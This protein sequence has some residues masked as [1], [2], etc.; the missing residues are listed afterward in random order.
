MKQAVVLI[1]GIGEQK[2]METLRR[3]VAAIL[4]PAAEGQEQYWSKPDR[5]SELFELRRLKTPGRTKTDFYEYYWAYQVEGTKLWHL[6]QWF[7]GLLFRRWR[8]I[9]PGL[10]GIWL[11]SWILLGTFSILAALGMGAYAKAWYAVQP[12]GSIWVV[13]ML[14]ITAMEGFLIYYVGD[15]ARY[16]SPS[17]GNIALRQKIRAEG[18]RLLRQLHDSHEYERII[19]VGHSL[20]SVIGYDIIAR[21]WLDYNSVYDF[22]TN[23]PIIAQLLVDRKQPQ[24]VISD[25]LYKTGAALSSDANSDALQQFREAQLDAWKEQRR[26]GNPWRVSDFVTMGSPLAH[27]ML[28]LASDCKDFEARKRQRELPSCP[29]VT[30]KKG[31][32]YND[33]TKHP[34]GKGMLFSPHILHH[35]AAFAVT[36]WTNLYFPAFFG[37]FGD[38][39]GGPLKEVFGRGIK[40]IPVKLTSWRRFTW[41]AHTAYWKVETTVPDKDSV[42]EYAV[43]ELRRALELDRIREFRIEKDVMMTDHSQTTMKELCELAS[44]MGKAEKERDQTFFKSMLAD[45]LMFRRASGIIVDKDTFLKDLLN[46][47][48]T[49]ETLESEDIVAQVHE[50]VAE[51]TLL[52][53]AIGLREGKPFDGVFR[54]IRIFVRESDKQPQWQL[55]TWFNVRVPDL[56]R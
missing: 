55:H 43:G 51:V 8:D 5:M 31:Y 1:H 7:F 10:Q 47:A 23:A 38:V 14:A 16:L 19:I 33:D 2:P 48:N 3:F 27:A 52:I 13:S 56:N 29:P 45:K 4:P 41:F 34:V 46:P 17:P 53:R 36:R 20:G 6:G 49:Y 9:P 50:G 28:L 21:L 39:I 15:A 12:Y 11:T 25:A 37:L 26:W 54:N 22:K 30:D 24:P 18:V 44:H 32:G 35:A 40:D 42:S